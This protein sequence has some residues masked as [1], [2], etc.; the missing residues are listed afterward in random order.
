MPAVY[1]T[2]L[3]SDVQSVQAGKILHVGVDPKLDAPVVVWHESVPMTN[4]LLHVVGTGHDIP[5]G[6]EYRGTA[7]RPDGFV[8]HV[9]EEVKF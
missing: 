3:W 1:K 9:Y 5:E 8:F 7:V 4:R 6:T 2:P